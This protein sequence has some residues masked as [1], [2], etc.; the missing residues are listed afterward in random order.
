MSD[1][2]RND[3]IGGWMREKKKKRKNPD[4]YSYLF[5]EQQLNVYYRSDMVLST[6]DTR[7]NK[8]KIF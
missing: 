7:V 1:W 6:G 5:L 3:W 8:L 4:Q 2:V